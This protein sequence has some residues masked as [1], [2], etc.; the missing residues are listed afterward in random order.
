MAL[1]LVLELALKLEKVLVLA[2]VLEMAVELALETETTILLVL[3]NLVSLDHHL[4]LKMV[5]RLEYCL[6]T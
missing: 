3:L 2:S 4:V 5:R 6:V 1:E